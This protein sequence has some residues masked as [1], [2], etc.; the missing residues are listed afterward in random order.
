MILERRKFLQQSSGRDA[1]QAVD[2]FRELMRR[3][4]QRKTRWRWST[5][6]SIA[7]KL[8]CASSNSTPTTSL[9]LSPISLVN[10]SR[11]YFALPVKMIGEQV[12]GVCA[13]LKLIFHRRIILPNASATNYQNKRKMGG[14][15]GLSLRQP[16]GLHHL[17]EE[18]RLRPMKC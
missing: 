10:T 8:H 3:R 9:S 18:R 11:R 5:S 6:V 13:K 2:D 12:S 7:S 1:F 17:P 15:I 4:G 16:N 14:F